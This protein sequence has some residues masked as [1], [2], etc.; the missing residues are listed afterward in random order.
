M[1]SVGGKTIVMQGML[2][3]LQQGDPRATNEL[4]EFAYDRLMMVTRKLLGSFGG[5]VGVE[6]ETAGVVN[7]AYNRLRSAIE[8]VR[9]TTVKLFMGLAA[10]KIRETLLDKVRQINGRGQDP[11]P[12]TQPIGNPGSTTSPGGVQIADTDASGS[13]N[14]TAL[15]L[16]EAIETLPDEEREVVELIFFHGYTQPEV[17]ELI[18]V[19]E[20]TIKRRWARAR[21]KLADRLHAFA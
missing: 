9:P 4:I 12:G 20:D 19:H 3:R 1:T 2:D 7:E 13:R 15:D 8:S 21:V 10:K 16:L 18:G 17:G 5:G 14:Q 11:R 6:E